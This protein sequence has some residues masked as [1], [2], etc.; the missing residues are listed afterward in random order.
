MLFS[1]F[2]IS[3]FYLK[4]RFSKSVPFRA[5]RQRCAAQGWHSSRRHSLT[6]AVARQGRKAA[7]HDPLLPGWR[8]R[9]VVPHPALSL[10]S[11]C[12]SRA[13]R[14]VAPAV[15]AGCCSQ[16]MVEKAG[17]CSA[18]LAARSDR[19]PS[20]GRASGHLL[21]LASRLGAATGFSKP[22]QGRAIRSR[23]K[24]VLPGSP[25]PASG[26]GGQPPGCNAGWLHLQGQLS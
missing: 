8:E 6:A 10:G 1:F 19:E 7:N 26:P 23:A 24:L 11:T 18:P 15:L 16:G 22:R 12:G 21:P 17:C 25:S 4:K 3:L 2:S 13:G 20:P 9:R 14:R 5:T